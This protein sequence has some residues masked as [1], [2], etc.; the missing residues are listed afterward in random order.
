MGAGRCGYFP[1]HALGQIASLQRVK[2]K[3]L[4]NQS[5]GLPSTLFAKSLTD[6]QCNLSSYIISYD[7][8]TE[9]GAVKITMERS[10]DHPQPHA[11]QGE[12]FKI[13]LGKMSRQ[14]ADF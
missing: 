6:S 14:A 9:I 3:C 13:F 1:A 10:N 8:D 7:D 12:A 5:L 2:L 4:T 11:D